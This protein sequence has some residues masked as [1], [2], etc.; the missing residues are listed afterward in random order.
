MGGNDGFPHFF[1][2]SNVLENSS[3][4]PEFYLSLNFLPLLQQLL[5]IS[6][7]WVAGTIFPFTVPSLYAL[8]K[9][10]KTKC[11]GNVSACVAK[12]RSV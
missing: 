6:W 5:K 9:I 11:L 2:N 1:I 7:L 10:F 8:I 12:R 3:K 4:P